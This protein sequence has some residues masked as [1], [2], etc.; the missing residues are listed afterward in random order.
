MVCPTSFLLPRFWIFMMIKINKWKFWEIHKPVSFPQIDLEYFSWVCGVKLFSERMNTFCLSMSLSSGCMYWPPTLCLIHPESGDC[1]SCLGTMLSEISIQTYSYDYEW[2][3]L[4]YPSV[5]VYRC[6]FQLQLNNLPDAGHDH[7]KNKKAKHSDKTD[8]KPER[9]VI[10]S[11]SW[12]I[13]TRTLAHRRAA[14]KIR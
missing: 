10:A 6:T 8:G 2:K 5:L 14:P 9:I 4:A 7:E 3:S 13:S 12:P 1:L 11:S